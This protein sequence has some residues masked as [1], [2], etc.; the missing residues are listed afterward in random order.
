MHILMIITRA[1][2]FGVTLFSSFVFSLASTFDEK[3]ASRMRRFQ[4]IVLSALEDD[5]S[6]VHCAPFDYDL[7]INNNSN[8][9]DFQTAR[10]EDKR[11]LHAKRTQSNKTFLTKIRKSAKVLRIWRLKSTPLR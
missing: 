7:K 2:A 9:D 1:F 11:L 3:V 6:E 8:K 5:G 10:S 4:V